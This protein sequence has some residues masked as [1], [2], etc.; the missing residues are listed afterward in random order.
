MKRRNNPI[1]FLCLLFLIS[2]GTDNHLRVRIE[3][4]RPTPVELDNFDTI[5]ITNFLIKEQ[6][7]DFNM[8]K[9]L[10]D[11]FSTELDQKAKKKISSLEI[12]LETEDVF[13]DKNSWQ[14][15]LPDK[16]KSLLFTGSLEFTEE[17]RKAIKSAE[18]RRF[19]SPFPEESRI[20]ERRFYSFSL[21]LYLIDPQTGEAL[22]DR[23]FKESK[24]YRNPNQTAY[25]AFYDMMLIVRD[26]FFRQILGEE[27]TQE[28]YLIK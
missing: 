20:E 7:K 21:H 23:S 17:I 3:M 26:K 11:Y 18:K 19:D 9:E 14:G 24:S 25:F 27:Q 13:K 16:N 2:C 12:S 6:A 10:T 8:N 5:V 28:R 4:P 1:L 22:Y 15:L